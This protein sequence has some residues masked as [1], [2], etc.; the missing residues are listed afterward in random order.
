MKA[1]NPRRRRGNPK[2][3]KVAPPPV[4]ANL[5]QAAEAC[6]YVGS[7]Y[8]KDRPGF[9]G[10]PR[11]RPDASLCPGNLA[12]RRRLVEGWLQDAVRAGHTG[13]WDRGFPRYVWYR[14]GGTVFEACPNSP[15]SGEYHG[16]PLE[17]CQQVRGLP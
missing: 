2:A 11:H 17:S 15:G 1:P 10:M 6:R 4:G 3:K 5:A 8:H 13:T 16:Y 7:P 12:N 14:Q 9:A